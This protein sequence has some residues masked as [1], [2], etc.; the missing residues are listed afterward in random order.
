MEG[1]LR[2][3]LDHEGWRL[4]EGPAW[5]SS[6][7]EQGAAACPVEVAA[8]PSGVRVVSLLV[9]TLAAPLGGVVAWKAAPGAHSGVGVSLGTWGVAGAMGDAAAA[10]AAINQFKQSLPSAGPRKNA[11]GQQEVGLSG[12]QCAT[13]TL[14]PAPLQGSSASVCGGAG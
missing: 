7:G 12:R 1:L 14:C 5:G 10:T 13:A 8:G 4:A 11:Y 3:E 2:S 9:P 6:R